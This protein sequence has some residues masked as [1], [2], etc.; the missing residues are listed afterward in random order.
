MSKG[1]STS[2]R[3]NEQIRIS[4]I[5]LIGAANEQIGVIDTYQALQMAREQGL[6]LV[7]VAPTE[8][9]PVCRIMDYGKFKYNQKKNLKKHHEQQIKEVRLRPRTDE[10]DRQI[11]V[12]NAIRF[13]AKGDKVQFT[14]QFRG[15]ERAHREIGTAIFRG[16]AESINEYVKIERPPLMDG[17]NM[18]MI[19]SPVKAAIEKAV[20][21]GKLAFLAKAVEVE[22]PDTDTDDEGGEPTP[23]A[24]AQ[25]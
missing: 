15:R 18:V 7:E 24:A 10:H 12:R 3:C 22:A 21:E 17:R 13:L 6:D 1:I 8:R 4:P 23:A 11:K 2:L 16:I 9:P 19:V 25:G 14:M 5:R 20:A